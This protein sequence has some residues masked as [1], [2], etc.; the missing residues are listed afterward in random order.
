MQIASALVLL[1]VIWFMALLIVLP[2]RIRSQGEAGQIT[3]GTPA[4][5]PVRTNMRKVF[6]TVTLVAVPVWL[7]ACALILL[8]VVTIDDIDLF[9]LIETPAPILQDE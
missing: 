1:A 8:K 6:K 7:G 9:W 5:A 3:M 2:F 4:S